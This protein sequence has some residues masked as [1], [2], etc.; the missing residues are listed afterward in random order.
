MARKLNYLD[1]LIHVRRYSSN[2]LIKDE[3]VSDH[4][5]CMISLAL[6]YVPELKKR[7]PGSN[8][9]LTNVLAGIA[10]HDV[11]ECLTGD[12][13]RPFK[14]H[15]D[16]ILQAIRH[17]SDVVLM[18]YIGSERYYYIKGITSKKTVQGVLI[19]IFDLAQAGY[20][21][22]SEVEL[23]NSY[24]ANELENV[25]DCYNEWIDDIKTSEFS[26][27]DIDPL[28]WLINEFYSEFVEFLKEYND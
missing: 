2:L 11:E 25:L 18:D 16:N 23:G 4:T 13:M 6:E 12:I 15:D 8:I 14:Y 5:W 9:E 22:K 27:C 21:M 26:Q 24:F 20:K 1:N 17:A 3:S 19:K 10:V 7:F 28:L